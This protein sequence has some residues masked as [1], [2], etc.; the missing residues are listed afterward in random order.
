MWIVPRQLLTSVSAQD[1]EELTLDSKEFSQRAE[2]SLMWRSKPSPARTWSQRWKRVSWMQHLCGRTLKPA[3][4]NSLVT[5]WTSSVAATRVSRSQQQ[6]SDLENRIPDTSG[7]LYRGQLDLF[8]R[9][10]AGLRM[11]KGIL[12]SALKTCAT[13]WESWVTSLRQEY[14][15]RLNA[16]QLTNAKGSLSLQGGWATPAA[17]DYKG[18]YRPESLIRKDGKSRM[19]GLPQQVE[20]DPTTN[21]PTPTSAEGSKIPDQANY[22]Q[23]GLSNH[24]AIVGHPDREKLN[25]SGKSQELWATPRADK[26]TAENLE[27]WEKRHKEGKVSQQPLPT[28]VQNWP[29]PDTQN[30]R[31]GSKR[32]KAAKGNHAVS[33]HHK[34]ADTENWRPPQAADSKNV[35]K[36]EMEGRVV[37]G[38]P[39]QKMLRQQVR[40]METRSMKLNPSW[41]EQLMGLPVGWTQL[42]TEWIVCGFSE[43]ES[44]PPPAK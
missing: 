40:T 2:Q 3:L 29:T 19:D 24:P 15:Q 26:Y 17:R 9:D 43:T 37:N 1:M 30:H 21:W 38:Q 4:G 20:Y 11:S 18:S 41:V 28:Q 42:P 32:R 13:T 23:V 16:A 8:V 14:S 33:L 6:A 25:K 36:K 39:A 34:I 31:D 7:H 5:E 44:S 27:S 22:G 10:T 12:P 35:G